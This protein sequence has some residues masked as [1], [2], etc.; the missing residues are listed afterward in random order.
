MWTYLLK[1][2]NIKCEFQNINLTSSKID[3]SGLSKQKLLGNVEFR[4]GEK[5]ALGWLRS[6]ELLNSVMATIGD[7]QTCLDNSMSGKWN[8][9]STCMKVNF[10][11]KFIL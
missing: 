6:G 1:G 9:Q 7:M 10:V 5:A 3:V 11:C 4:K 8:T 2:T